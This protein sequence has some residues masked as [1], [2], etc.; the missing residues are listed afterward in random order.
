MTHPDA[1][2]IPHTS[3]PTENGWLV[4]DVWESE[5]AFRQFGEALGPILRELGVEGV[6]P[7]T[8][9]VLNVVTR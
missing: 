6:R 7:R 3:A 1:G 8:C 5:E 2:L 4:V 9:P